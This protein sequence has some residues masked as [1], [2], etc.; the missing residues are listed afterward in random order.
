MISPDEVFTLQLLSNFPFLVATELLHSVFIRHRGQRD[1]KCVF[2]EFY[3]Y[4]YTDIR[5]HQERKH[6][7]HR[8]VM[9]AR[10]CMTFKSEHLLEVLH[11]NF[12][13]NCCS[14]PSFIQAVHSAGFVGVGGFN[15]PR[16]HS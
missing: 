8:S 7:G 9:C 14:C 3:G 11:Q 1:Y 13:C 6:A 4:T 16:R 5:K 12:T 15:L 10:C 2:C